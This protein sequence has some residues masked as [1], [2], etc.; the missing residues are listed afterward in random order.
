[1]IERNKY[2]SENLEG[3]ENLQT[4]AG[5]KINQVA[6]L[7]Q[8]S[9]KKYFEKIINSFNKTKI[10]ERWLVDEAELM[11]DPNI[12][13]NSINYII[14]ESNDPSIK[15]I[16][17]SK[18]LINGPLDDKSFLNQIPHI[19]YCLSERYRQEYLK[20]VSIHACAVEKDGKGILIL[21]DKGTGKTNLL[22][23]LCMNHAYRFIGNDI[24]VIGGGEKLTLVFGNQ[25]INVRVETIRNLNP[26]FSARINLD[27][28]NN[29]YETKKSYSTEELGINNCN[30]EVVLSHIVRINTHITNGD[31]KETPIL[32]L[33]TEALRLNE[34]MSRYIRGM[35]T[36]LMLSESGSIK[37]YFPSQDNSEL[38]N[39][40]NNLVERFL[41][42]VPFTYISGDE[43]SNIAKKYDLSH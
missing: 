35:T 27:D 9:E 42:E 7:I 10:S 36:P 18:Y 13:N 23:A 43:S 24:V 4:I 19:C 28:L 3:N 34:N 31:Y 11:N 25:Q 39:F 38:C 41:N 21:G 8:G 32:S 29:G 6:F 12:Q 1:M 37:G 22:I 15:V 40:R 2:N 17:S 30:H 20:Q 14:N 16:D 5:G 26:L 33:P